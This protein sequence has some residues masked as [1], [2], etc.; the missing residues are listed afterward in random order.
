MTS[1][2][3]GIRSPV[4]MARCSALP[5]STTKTLDPPSVSS[6]AMRGIVSASA[7]RSKTMPTRANMPG[8]RSPLRIVD[9]ERHLERAVAASH[10]GCDQFDDGRERRPARA[11]TLIEGRWT[12]LE[13]GELALGHVDRWP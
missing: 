7:R 5:R 8:L 12:G 6:S 10:G 13:P 9:L 1:I 3:A 4:L 2:L 11:S